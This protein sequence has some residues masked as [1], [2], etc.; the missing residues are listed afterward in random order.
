MNK[1]LMVCRH[2]KQ[3]YLSDEWKTTGSIYG[4]CSKECRKEHLKLCV[5]SN[6]TNTNLIKTL[7]KI[8]KEAEE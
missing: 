5:P 2:C 6:V 1:L 8:S 4:F 3:K 7:D